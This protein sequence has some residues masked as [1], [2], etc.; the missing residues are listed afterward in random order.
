[1]LS[2]DQ[3]IEVETYRTNIIARKLE[4][5]PEAA[6]F[7]SPSNVTG[8]VDGGNDLGKLKKV[9]AIGNSAAAEI[10]KH[11]AQ[12]LIADIPHQAELFALLCS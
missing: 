6:I 3:V 11:G 12:P 10:K 7:Y 2:P 5:L 8:F 4:N 1:M 9:I